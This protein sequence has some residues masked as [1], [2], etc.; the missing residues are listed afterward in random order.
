MAVVGLIRP[1]QKVVRVLR[2]HP[3]KND[4]YRQGGIS[5][6]GKAIDDDALAACHRKVQKPGQHKQ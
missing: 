3:R 4:L 2:L 6:E 5:S 1:L